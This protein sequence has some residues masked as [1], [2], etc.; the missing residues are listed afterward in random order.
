[1]MYVNDDMN[2][3]LD[4]HSGV[5]KA[6]SVAQVAYRCRHACIIAVKDGHRLDQISF[7]CIAPYHD[8]V[9]SGFVLGTSIL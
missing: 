5:L 8:I 6:R 2:D 7:V 4:K 9:I 1:M 3:T